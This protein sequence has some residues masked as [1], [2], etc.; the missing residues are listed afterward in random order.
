MSSIKYSLYVVTNKDIEK[1]IRKILKKFVRESSNSYVGLDFEF[2]KVSREYKDVALMQISLSHNDGI[3]TH[4]LVL[5]PESIQEKTMKVI[6]RMLTSKRITKILHGAESLDISYVYRQLLISR[7]QIS[8]FAKSFYDTKL[9]CDFMKVIHNPEQGESNCSI[10]EI[11]YNNKVINKQ[12]YE[13][14]NNID[15]EKSLEE[16]IDI[17]NLQPILLEY[18]IRDALYL[19][20]L[21][22]AYLKYTQYIPMYN[23]I[24]EIYEIVTIS[25][26]A[27][28]TKGT[29]IGYPDIYPKIIEYTNKLNLVK[30][31][32]RNISYNT[33][34]NYY[35]KVIHNKTINIL[36]DI[37]YFKK[38]IKTILK[39]IIYL[40]ASNNLV[41][42]GFYD[43]LSRDYPILSL[44]VL[45]PYYSY[46]LN[47]YGQ[48]K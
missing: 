36:H 44:R 34:F 6:H 19:P 46:I 37:N 28:S 35:T 9:I 22:K 31:K 10:Y 45:T 14:L 26:N 47:R 29:F 8:K 12:T 24:R 33:L 16:H 30:L 1:K 23:L 27:L 39:L 13:E 3:V 17:H 32:D 5:H 11:L 40:V 7:K 48:R 18:A 43:Q 4:V 42:K 38:F 25:K 20:Q 41:L 2:N 15:K 21:M